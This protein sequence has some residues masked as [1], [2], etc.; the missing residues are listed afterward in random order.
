MLELMLL[1]LFKVFLE[2][3]FVRLTKNVFSVV[4]GWVFAFLESLCSSS[5]IS[6]LEARKVFSILVLFRGDA[7][8][9][10]S[11]FLS[12]EGFRIC[13]LGPGP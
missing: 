1:L 10:N 9:K 4:K 2:L 11:F 7:L 5:K 3:L 12:G 13:S 8:R 6:P